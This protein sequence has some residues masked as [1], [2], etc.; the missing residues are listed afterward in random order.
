MGEVVLT[1]GDGEQNEYGFVQLVSFR[2]LL[3]PPK[4]T[5]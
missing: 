1:Q 5:L 2:S 4:I 3:V